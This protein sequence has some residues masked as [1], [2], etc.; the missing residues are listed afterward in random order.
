[1]EDDSVRP[2]ASIITKLM[3]FYARHRG[4]N[5]AMNTFVDTVEHNPHLQLDITRDPNT[6]R[7]RTTPQQWHIAPH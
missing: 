2:N 5:H 7:Q 4:V 1:M 3:P 6:D